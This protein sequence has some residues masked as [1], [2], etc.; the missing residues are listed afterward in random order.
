MYKEFGRTVFSIGSSGKSEGTSWSK[1]FNYT[2]L[3]K[4]GAF[5]K[6]QQQRKFIENSRKIIIKL[7]CYKKEKKNYK[8]QYEIN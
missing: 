8:M 2:N 7:L 4:S 1:L 3:L 5:Y 6:V